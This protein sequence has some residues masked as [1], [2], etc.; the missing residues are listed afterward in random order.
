MKIFNIKYTLKIQDSKLFKQLDK[1]LES[2][3]TI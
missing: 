1:T 3:H 2:T